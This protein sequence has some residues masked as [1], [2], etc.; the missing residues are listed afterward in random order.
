MNRMYGFGISRGA[1]L[2]LLLL[3][4]VPLPGQSSSFVVV[5]PQSATLLVGE[6]RSF[7]L[8]DQN[9]QLQ[10]NVTWTV[11]EPG[12]LQANAGDELAITAEKTG[13]FHISAQ[14]KNGSADATVRVMEGKIP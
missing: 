9:G 14:S 6:Y 2:A 3:W 7:R 8:A 1:R 13:D 10:R 12:A 5:T 4:A 11:S